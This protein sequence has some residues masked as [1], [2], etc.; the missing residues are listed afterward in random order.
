MRGQQRASKAVMAHD[1]EAMGLRLCQHRVGDDGADGRGGGVHAL[2]AHGGIARIRD[3]LRQAE[4]AE[5]TVLFERRRPEM[6]P[7]HRRRA[8]RIDGDD[9]RDRVAGWDE[10]A[11]AEPRPPLKVAVVAPVPAP[12]VPSAKEPSSA[13]R[14]AS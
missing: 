4:A 13:A 14:K 6:R 7:C 11:L 2:E 12:T 5:F 3:R 10:R 9:G 1:G 8:E